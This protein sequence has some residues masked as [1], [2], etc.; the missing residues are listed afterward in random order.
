M[1]KL[2]DITVGSHLT[3]IAGTEPVDVV[4]VQWYGNNV[5]EITYKNSTGIPGTQLLYRENEESIQ[6]KDKH[7]P[8]SF[9]ADGNQMRLASE[10]YRI[11][12]AHLFDPY[13]AV[14]TSS[15]EPRCGNDKSFASSVFVY[16]KT[17]SCLLGISPTPKNS[18]QVVWLR[19]RFLNA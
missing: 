7:L 15:V 4:A 13:L 9:D 1:A 6:V 2:E 17:S 12:L 8:W 18:P 5:I 19:I 16:T 3:G 10:T 14:H 11:G